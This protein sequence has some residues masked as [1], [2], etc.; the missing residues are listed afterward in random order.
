MSV[1]LSEKK[2]VLPSYFFNNFYFSQN[3]VKGEKVKTPPSFVKIHGW[4]GKQSLL[5]VPL[6]KQFHHEPSEYPVMKVLL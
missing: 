5:L 2:P 4:V 1:S 3:F 6:V